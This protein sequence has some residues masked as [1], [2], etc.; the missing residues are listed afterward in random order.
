MS[1]NPTATMTMPKIITGDVPPDEAA[2]TVEACGVP[3]TSPSAAGVTAPSAVA[4]S[5]GLGVGD[6]FFDG[7]GDGVTRAPVTR[8]VSLPR[9][10]PDRLR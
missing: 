5:V 8:A 1:S 3:D 6:A 10:P 4:T 7:V 2:A 9:P